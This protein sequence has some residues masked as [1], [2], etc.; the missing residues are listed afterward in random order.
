MEKIKKR[1]IKKYE[2]NILDFYMIVNI[3]ILYDCYINIIKKNSKYK[4]KITA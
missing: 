3:N 1:I 2:I 4:K